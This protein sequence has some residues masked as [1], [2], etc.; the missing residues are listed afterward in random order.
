MTLPVVTLLSE[1]LSTST[2]HGLSYFGDRKRHWVERTFWIITFLTSMSG[3]FFMVHKTYSKWQQSPLIVTQDDK[4]TPI[5]EIPFPAVT[6]C[7]SIK[8]AYTDTNLTRT[9]D[10]LQNFLQGMEPI[11][12]TIELGDAEKATLN[13][14][15]DD[16]RMLIAASM[17]C[18]KSFGSLVPIVSVPGVLKHSETENLFKMHRPLWNRTFELYS[19]KGIFGD[20][21]LPWVLTEDGVCFTFNSQGNFQVFKKEA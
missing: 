1:Y 18:V 20:W 10:I 13:I 5:S 12:K 21:I 4:F 6:I 9:F 8:M 11:D 7:P 15:N 3:C 2:I 16:V 14:T 17:I 19:F